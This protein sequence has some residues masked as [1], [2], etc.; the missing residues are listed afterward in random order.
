MT[1][2]DDGA[3]AVSAR[4]R[5]I[6]RIALSAVGAGLLYGTWAYLANSEFGRASATR[7]GAVQAVWS[8]VVT[9]VL[10]FVIEHR[11]RRWR[12]TRLPLRRVA[13]PPLLLVWAG[14]LAVHVLNHTP[15][16]G[17]TIAPVGVIG[18]VFVC[19]YVAG[20]ARLERAP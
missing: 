12:A 2:R 11:A 10:A 9:V 4:L 20:L 17:R 18:T 5:S 6:Q 7:A 1:V 15:A 13:L 8:V 19:A 16:V 14:P 3:R